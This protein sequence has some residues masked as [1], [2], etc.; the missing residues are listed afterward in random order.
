MVTTVVHGEEVWSE[1]NV[2]TDIELTEQQLRQA[3]LS[4]PLSLF[5]DWSL[6][7]D[8][9][10]HAGTDEIDGRATE[11]VE[12]LA[13]GLE[14]FVVQI[15]AEN[16]DILQVT[17]QEPLGRGLPSVQVVTRFGEH[18]DVGGLR[19]VH[20]EAEPELAEQ[21]LDLLQGL[22]PEVLGLEHLLLTPP[23]QVAQRVD[24]GVLQAVGAADRQLK[25][26]DTAIEVLVDRRLGA[27]CFVSNLRLK[28]LIKVDEE[29]NLFLDNLR[30][31]S[32]RVIRLDT[33]IRVD[34]KD[35]LV[36]VSNLTDTRITHRVIYLFDRR[37]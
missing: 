23:H 19:H 32:E 27:F 12:L 8:D 28:V 20:A 11:V 5:T 35:Q 14:P 2:M 17:S 29:L 34:F 22:A 10:R 21:L 37:E 33:T 36:I 15:D 26:I 6:F 3:R 24:V 13:E 31:I 9:A 1:S 30:R 25:L 18:R 16:G 4:H 7:F